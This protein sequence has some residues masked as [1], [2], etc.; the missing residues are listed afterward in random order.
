[1]LLRWLGGERKVWSVVH[2][3]TTEAEA[4]RRLTREIDT[5]REDRKRVRNRIQGLLATQGVRLPLTGNFLEQVRTAQTGDGR[6]LPRPFARGSNTSGHIWTR[7]RRVWT[8]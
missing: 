4:Q 5:V 2:V 1:V 8:R 6:L 7:S 3:P